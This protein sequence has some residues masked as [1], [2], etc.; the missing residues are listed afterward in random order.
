MTERAELL[1]VLEGA[2]ARGLVGPGPLG[3]HV[4]HALAWAEALEPAPARFLDLGTGAGVPG[5]VLALRW[6]ATTAVLL[7]SRHR[8]VDWV[9]E[10]AARLGVEGRV[11]WVEARA[12]A[13]GRDPRLREAFPL[14]VA[15]GFGA[16]AI[17]AECGAAFVVPGG[18]LSVSEPPEAATT[19]AG[20]SGAG[21]RWP[22][23][24]LA[25]LG[26]RVGSRTGTGAATFVVLEKTA[27]LDDRW[28]RPV[29]RPGRR[30]LWS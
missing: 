7:D 30:P 13:A 4:D 22:E 27:P 2:R 28:P 20:A 15:R 24:V 19:E 21:E 25:E 8:S 11:E 5:L 1:A 6:P 23:A 26:L 12:E 17:T 16:P 14:V 18:R 29:G 3:I 10:A 9:G